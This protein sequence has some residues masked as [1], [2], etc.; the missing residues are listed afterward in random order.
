MRVVDGSREILRIRLSDAAERAVTATPE[1]EESWPYWSSSAG[2]LV[3]AVPTTVEDDE[4][5]SG[6]H[7]PNDYFYRIGFTESA[8][9]FQ[10]DNFGRGGLG[11]DP[12]LGDAQDSADTLTDGDPDNDVDNNANFSTPTDGQS[13][14]MQMF[15]WT[16]PPPLRDGDLD[17]DIIIHELAHGVSTRLVAGRGATACLFGVQ[18]GAMGEAWGDYFAGSYFDDPVLAAGSTRLAGGLLAHEDPDS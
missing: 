1:R 13:G 10:A 6:W 7:M 5:D 11:G 12:V 4:D 2:R 15:L 18:S 8:G 9:N 3:F 14:R 16:D 17:I